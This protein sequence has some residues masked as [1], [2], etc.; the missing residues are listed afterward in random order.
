MHEIPAWLQFLFPEYALPVIFGFSLIYSFTVPL[1]EEIVLMLIGVLAKTYGLPFWEVA[2]ASYPGLVASDFIY[3][4]LARY[5][6]VKLLRTR[7]GKFLIKPEK[8]LASELFFACKG[9]RI[10]FF[11]RFLVGIRLP[12][13]IAS[14]I[15]RMPF[16]VFSFYNSLAAAFATAGWLGLGYF[17]GHSLGSDMNIVARTFALLSPLFVLIALLFLLRKLRSDQ[18][19][20]ERQIPGAGADETVVERVEERIE[21]MLG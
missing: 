16:R 12:A 10:V 15:F 18:K 21:E 1:S 5:F 3:Y 7:L 20:I 6:G 9:N 8:V 11:C 19:C 13:I 17:W 4:G 2:A 14:G